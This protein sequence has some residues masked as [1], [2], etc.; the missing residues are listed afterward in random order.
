MSQEH[1]AL[2]SILGYQLKHLQSVLR[3]RMDEALRPLGLSTP[4]Y[5]CLEQLRRRPGASNS[6][7]AR[8]GFVTR[9][10]MNTVLRGLQERELVTRPARAESGRV[11]PTSLTA[12]GDELLDQAVSRIDEINARMLS[13]LDEATQAQVAEA[14]DRCIAALEMP[15]DA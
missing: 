8:G 4:Q 12:T 14:L 3:S 11:L 9:Q 13:P 2:E 7:L 1:V 10:T 5:V 6:E 15:D